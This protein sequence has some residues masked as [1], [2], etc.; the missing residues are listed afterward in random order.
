MVD[1]AFGPADH[2]DLPLGLRRHPRFAARL[3]MPVGSELDIVSIYSHDPN[4]LDAVV[5][6]LWQPTDRVQR[7]QWSDNQQ[8]WVEC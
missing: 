4:H 7:E 6:R 5:M 3:L 8:K 1:T 2:P